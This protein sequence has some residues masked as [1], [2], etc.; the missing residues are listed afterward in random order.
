MTRKK[1]VH[2]S[3]FIFTFVGSN[4]SASSQDFAQKSREE[5]QINRN[6]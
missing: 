3:L 5:G 4:F 1:I 2:E 6:L